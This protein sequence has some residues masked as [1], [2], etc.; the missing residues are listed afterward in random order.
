MSQLDD[1]KILEGSEAFGGMGTLGIKIEIAGTCVPKN[2]DPIRYI[3]YKAKRDIENALY[4][5]FYAERPET[6]ETV[7]KERKEILGLF[8][9]PI[10]VED[11]PNGYSSDD[12]YFS[13]YPWFR[14]TTKI[15]HFVIGWRKRVVSIDWESTIC[16]K[17]AE[18]LFPE[19]DVTKS[20]FLIHAWSLE[21]AKE[22]IDKVIA[23][24]STP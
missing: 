20:G 21:K 15:G 23:T 2:L 9:S 19:E 3:S 11:L 13:H 18:D 7:E 16:D 8:D 17:W 6:K 5:Q 10:Y 4:K 24:A 22:Y 14:V 1:Y 12:Y